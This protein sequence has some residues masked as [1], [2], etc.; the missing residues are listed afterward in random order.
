M[1]K[2]SNNVTKDATTN[3]GSILA[4]ANYPSQALTYADYVYAIV[5]TNTRLNK[6][7]KDKGTFSLDYILECL[8]SG[9][10]T[11]DLGIFE[12][13]LAGEEALIKAVSGVFNNIMIIEYLHYYNIIIFSK[14]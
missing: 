3:I 1:G 9:S 10:G 14:R 8:A 7:I 4:P 11:E 5:K 2:I 12:T 13:Y 6:L